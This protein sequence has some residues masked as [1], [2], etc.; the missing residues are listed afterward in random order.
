MHIGVQNKITQ[1][2]WMSMQ[3]R[4]YFSRIITP[5]RSTRAGRIL[6]IQVNWDEIEADQ[7]K[8]QPWVPKKPTKTTNMY[9]TVFTTGVTERWSMCILKMC[10]YFNHE[11]FLLFFPPDSWCNLTNDQR[12]QHCNLAK[13]TFTRIKEKHYHQHANALGH[14]TSSKLKLMNIC[15]CSTSWGPHEETS[16]LFSLFY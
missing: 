5:L 6:C 3:S 1:C 13:S 8:L 2:Q 15:A 14:Y 16:A 12:F 11:L 10:M 9:F 4:F 7:R